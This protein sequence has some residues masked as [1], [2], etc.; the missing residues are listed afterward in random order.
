MTTPSLHGLHHLKLPVSDLDASIDWYRHA[1]GA[2]HLEQFDHIDDD[3]ERYAVIM[4]LPGVDVP[5]ELRWAPEGASAMRQCDPIM[6]AVDTRE[7][8]DEWA[9]HFDAVGADHS[10][11]MKGGAGHLLV[12]ADPDGIY[13]RF[14]DLPTG[15]VANITMPKGNP[16]PGDPW[17]NPPP[18]Q[19]PRRRVGR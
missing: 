11:V 14:G 18:M 8:L 2:T 15:G 13:I 7:R 10:P 9:E 17:L 1:L 3:G 5:L 16:E 12:V 4:A 19:H 6:L